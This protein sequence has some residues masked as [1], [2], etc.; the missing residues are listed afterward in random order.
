MSLNRCKH[1]ALNAHFQKV[2]TARKGCLY[3]GRR[4]RVLDELCIEITCSVKPKLKCAAL[5][6]SLRH[7]IIVCT[8]KI[9]NRVYRETMCEVMYIIVT[10]VRGTYG[11][12]VHF[13]RTYRQFVE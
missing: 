12:N 3:F 8:V 11:T 5:C 1:F 2:F 7:D 9:M 6:H 10:T 4:R 13:H